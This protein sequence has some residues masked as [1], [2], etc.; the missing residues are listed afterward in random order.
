MNVPRAHK[1][2]NNTHFFF[3]KMCKPCYDR[4]LKRMK[5][6]VSKMTLS[7]SLLSHLDHI[8]ENYPTVHDKQHLGR[9]GEGE[10]S[11]EKK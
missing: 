11:K 7:L 4:I 2:S 9:G 5:R 10:K 3:D 6:K 8:P 1:S